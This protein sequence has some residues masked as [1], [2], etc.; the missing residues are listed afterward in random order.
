MRSTDLLSA[1][2]RDARRRTLDL[3]ADLDDDVLLG[4]RL[5]TVN[6]LRWE[7]GHVAWFQERWV[8][9]Q[10]RGRPPL[11][12]DAD[13]IWDSSA[14]AHDT[15]WDLPLPS[16]ADTLA[17]MR[18]VEEHVLRAIEEAPSADVR[19]FTEYTVYHE[20]MHD[21]A[22]AYTRQTLGCPAPSPATT[23]FPAV[24]GGA[25]P[26]D[27]AV[28]GGALRLGAEESEPFVFD[29]EKWA[30]LVTVA[31]FRI[32]RA[33]VTAAEFAAF[34]DDGGYGRR[35][36]WSDAGW[37]WRSTA[38]AEQPVYWRRGDGG[39]ER[40]HFDSWVPLEPHHP[41]LHVSAHEA[42]AWCAWADRRLPTEAEWEMAAAA[43][44]SDGGAKRRFPWGDEPPMPSR[45][46]LDGSAGG[47][48]EVGALPAGDSACGC[49][50][51]LGNVWEW[52][53]SDFAPY[54]GF[55]ADAY[56]DYSAPW[57]GTHRVLRGGCWATRARLLRNTWRNFYTPDRRDVWAGFRTCARA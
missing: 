1:W 17:Y 23:P 19:Y 45:A 44:A 13:R 41:V 15:R 11:R 52:T 16:R 18:D 43:P 48:V 9:R 5:P 57:F 21:E 55:V 40:R 25:W 20:D 34:V 51:M 27:V 53:S 28:L 46:N 24:G 35:G 6:P 8:L 10:A 2:V 29:N 12:P 38:R 49:R 22:L 50:Q 4:P 14:I 33:P 30:H 32:A 39:W 3:V 54:P 37:A 42:E 7:I 26:G 31:P 56:A 36:L 47:S